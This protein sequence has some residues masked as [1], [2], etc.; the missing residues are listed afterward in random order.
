MADTLLELSS[1][2]L[3]KSDRLREAFK[4][5][6]PKALDAAL[7]R[8]EKT[9][10]LAYCRIMLAAGDP[11]EVRD[12]LEEALIDHGLTV[13]DLRA[14]AAQAKGPESDAVK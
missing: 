2:D 12:L 4:K 14:M 5:G 8:L 9:D 3:A 7:K 1:E 13:A 11:K 6:G 10:E